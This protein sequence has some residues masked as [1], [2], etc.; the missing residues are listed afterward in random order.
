MDEFSKIYDK[1][2]TPLNHLCDNCRLD[3]EF[4]ESDEFWQQ[5]TEN[6][7]N[8][9]H[10]LTIGKN[11]YE[12]YYEIMNILRENFPDSTDAEFEQNIES[13]L[14]RILK[15]KKKNTKRI[16]QDWLED[17]FKKKRK[18]E[19]YTCAGFVADYPFPGSFKIDNV[20]I[21]PI[22]STEI[23]N[24]EFFKEIDSW[25][26]MISNPVGM[27]AMF[28]CKVHTY[29]NDSCQ[30]ISN[31][32]VSRVLYFIKLVDPSSE[33]RLQMKDYRVA[34]RSEVIGTG[35]KSHYSRKNILRKDNFM[36]SSYHVEQINS[37]RDKAEKFFFKKD[38]TGFQQAILSALYWYGRVDVTFDDYI[39]QYLSYINGL[40]RLVLFDVKRN[41]AEMF[42]KRISC[43]FPTMDKKKISSLYEKRNDLLHEN[44]CIVSK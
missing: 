1:I 18:L 39:D 8:G 30:L 43:R 19:Y 21:A 7:D 10:I 15:D 12:P 42:G 6:D 3:V 32:R 20:L 29:N 31:I 13:L 26:K 35:K 24:H 23:K 40:E 9:V 41:K 25:S 4:D 14:F 11:A 38:N 36:R 44:E 16:A 27:N 22:D 2:H 5:K 33:V 17:I 37:I 28:V 34:G